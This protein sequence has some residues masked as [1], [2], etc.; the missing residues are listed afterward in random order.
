MK[1][2]K[3]LLPFFLFSLLI[4]TTF[5]SLSNNE[6]GL[7]KTDGDASEFIV[8]NHAAKKGFIDLK[9]VVLEELKK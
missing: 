8:D 6:K 7:E 3:F 2:L 5:A 1:L 4:N 9:S